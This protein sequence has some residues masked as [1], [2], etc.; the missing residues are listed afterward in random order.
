MSSQDFSTI[1]L[2]DEF[3]IIFFKSVLESETT[4]NS[5]GPYSQVHTLP[6]TIL[7]LTYFK[8]KFNPWKPA[9]LLSFFLTR[10]VQ[11]HFPAPQPKPF[12]LNSSIIRES[13][14]G[15]ATVLQKLLKIHSFVVVLLYRKWLKF[16]YFC[17]LFFINLIRIEGRIW[18]P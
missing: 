16:W 11:T 15:D 1:K 12:F 7:S 3:L 4:E 14:E 5:R 10:A 13:T 6:L 18:I 9:F 2:E 8:Y 17:T